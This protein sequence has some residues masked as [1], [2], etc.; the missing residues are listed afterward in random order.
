MSFEK[1]KTELAKKYTLKRNTKSVNAFCSIRL[2]T[3]LFTVMAGVAAVEEE[4]LQRVCAMQENT[5]GRLLNGW[6]RKAV[7]AD[8]RNE[9]LKALSR[10]ERA[11]IV[12]FDKV[13]FFMFDSQKLYILMD[14]VIKSASN[15]INA[16]KRR[17][18][19]DNNILPP[20]KI[21]RT[22]AERMQRVGVKQ[23]LIFEM[24]IVFSCVI[25][26]TKSTETPVLL[27]RGLAKMGF[28][29]SSLFGREEY[30]ERNSTIQVRA[31]ETEEQTNARLSQMRIHNAEVNNILM[32]KQ[33]DKQINKQTN[34][35]FMVF[36]RVTKKMRSKPMQ[37]V[38]K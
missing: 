25:K 13:I 34:K 22:P 2:V 16:L 6:E 30:L 18:D 19:F 35:Q 21:P 15:K 17:P 32:M 24:T 5:L 20:R 12:D 11:Q 27:I 28:E 7:A 8:L 10:E 9:K 14:K 4:E 36:R 23:E 26:K 33:T 3:L 37:G 29:F 31:D 38:L 1:S